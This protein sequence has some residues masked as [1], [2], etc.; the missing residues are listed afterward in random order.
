[1][2]SVKENKESIESEEQIVGCSSYTP[3]LPW[4][5]DT[6]SELTTVP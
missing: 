3:P 2:L 6:L 1:M 4:Y 5:I